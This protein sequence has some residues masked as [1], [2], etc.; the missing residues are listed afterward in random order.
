MEDCHEAMRHYSCKQLWY[1]YFLAKKAFRD[2]MDQRHVV[3]LCLA[4]ATRNAW[5]ELNNKEGEG[6]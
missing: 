2:S 1:W 6:E 4:I 3:G 5:E